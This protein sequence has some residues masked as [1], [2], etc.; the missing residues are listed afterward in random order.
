MDF[1]YNYNLNYNSPTELHTS[2]ITHK[3]FSSHPD[4]QLRTRKIFS[5]QPLVQPNNWLCPLLITFQHGP[6]RSTRFPAETI[7]YCF[8]IRC[9]GN[10]FSE[11]LPGNDRC[12][13]MAAYQYAYTPQYNKR[14]KKPS[15]LSFIKINWKVF[16]RNDLQ[17]FTIYTLFTFIWRNMAVINFFKEIRVHFDPSMPG[18]W[19]RW[20]SCP[21]TPLYGPHFYKWRL[22]LMNKKVYKRC[23][24]NS[25]IHFWNRVSVGNETEELY[26]P[27][28]FTDWKPLS[29]PF[30]SY[31]WN[32]LLDI[33]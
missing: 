25:Y 32:N 29:V 24:K 14:L 11:P 26:S 12:C 3:V 23:L 7:Y 17:C 31:I 13:R 22:G 15:F 9:R 18:G 20:P 27:I 19:A 5:S 16:S 33:W 8:R 30:Q 28:T 21:P 2:N 4:F 10:V 1:N 6:Y